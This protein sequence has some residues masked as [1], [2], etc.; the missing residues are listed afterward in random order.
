[1]CIKHFLPC[2]WQILRFAGVKFLKRFQLVDNLLGP[3]KAKTD[4]IGV[5]KLVS[6]HEMANVCFQM[7]NMTVCGMKLAAPIVVQQTEGWGSKV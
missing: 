7:A 1:M 5:H 2:I 3:A 6:C 4:K